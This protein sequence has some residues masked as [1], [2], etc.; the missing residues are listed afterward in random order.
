[1]NTPDNILAFPL[2]DATKAYEARDVSIIVADDDP[3]QRNAL[4]SRLEPWG[5]KPFAVRASSSEALVMLDERLPGQC[6][7]LL[8]LHTPDTEGAEI[9]RH[10]SGRHQTTELVLISG[11]VDRVS[12]TIAGMHGLRVMGRTFG[13]EVVAEGVE[14]EKGGAFLREYGCEY[15]QS[16]LIVRPTPGEQIGEWK[17][18]RKEPIPAVLMH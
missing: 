18:D 9:L 7:I 15:A 1:M 6:L 16:Y 13:M 17:G 14:D 11:A 5:S 4:S 10:L 2:V 8:D 12:D 3:L